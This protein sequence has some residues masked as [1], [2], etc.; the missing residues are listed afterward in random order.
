MCYKIDKSIA[1]LLVK[2]NNRFVIYEF[3]MIEKQMGYSS[4]WRCSKIL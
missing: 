2:E 3:L 1:Q 4:Y